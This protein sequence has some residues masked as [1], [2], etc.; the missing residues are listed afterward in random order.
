MAIMMITMTIMIYKRTDHL[1]VVRS[2]VCTGEN[3]DS[4]G[5][6]VEF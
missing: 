2:F 4:D 3:N 5:T 1:R 6:N